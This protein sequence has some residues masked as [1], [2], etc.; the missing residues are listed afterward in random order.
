MSSRNWIA[1]T[2]SG[3]SLW[4]SD[5]S[6]RPKATMVSW[7]KFG[8]V[9]KY[10]ISSICWS[11][12]SS[13]CPVLLRK[14]SYRAVPG[15]DIENVEN[16]AQRPDLPDERKRVADG[17][18]C[19]TRRAIN[20]VGSRKDTVPGCQLERLF[21]L[22]GLNPFTKDPVSDLFTTAFHPK[23]DLHATGQPHTK[24][25]IFIQHIDPGN[26]RPGDVQAPF[27]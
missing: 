13:D 8:S 15:E 18:P 21:N 26:S 1:S 2:K 6:S 23:A 25:H 9:S 22:T 14:S 24:K 16:G 3:S 10:M 27:R 7:S 20:E 4:N 12:R 19:F 5:L 17:I 11:H